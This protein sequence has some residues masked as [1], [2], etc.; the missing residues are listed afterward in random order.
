MSNKKQ[1]AESILAQEIP[2]IIQREL[3]DPRLGFITITKVELAKDYRSARVYFSALGTTGEEEPDKQIHVYETVLNNSAGVVQRVI[4]STLN[5]RFTPKLRFIF[6]D[7]LRKSMEMSD[8][9]RKARA[10]DID[11][12][13]EDG[14]GDE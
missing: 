14:D 5:M 9:I 7:S 13:E 4:A 11:R 8:L 3:S 10:S 6:S 1:R 12:T 2:A